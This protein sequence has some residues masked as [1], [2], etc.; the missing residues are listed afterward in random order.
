VKVREDI[1]SGMKGKRWDG[2]QVSELIERKGK[3]RNNTSLAWIK[4]PLPL[5]IAS[6]GS[7]VVEKIT[8][9]TL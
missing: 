2:M 6:L 3:Q 4:Q 8:S 9:G 1:K 7:S 5:T